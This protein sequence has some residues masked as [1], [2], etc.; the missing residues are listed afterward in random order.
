VYE[1]TQHNGSLRRGVMAT[2]KQHPDKKV[3]FRGFHLL[4]G[5]IIKVVNTSNINQVKLICA[6]GK[7]L[8][9]NSDGHYAGIPI[10]KVVKEKVV[11]PYVKES[12]D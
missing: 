5:E 6:S 10:V 4:E 2:P 11:Q 12:H 1:S 9:I 3:A 7:V 8:Y